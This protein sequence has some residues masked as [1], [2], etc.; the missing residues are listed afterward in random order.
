M[1]GRLHTAALAGLAACTLLPT[2]VMAANECA[3]QSDCG[4]VFMNC[5]SQVCVHKG[6]FPPTGIE[7]G[8]II[9]L[10]ILLGFANN[11]GIGGG[12]LIIP[13]CI[14]MFGFNT[15]QAI[16][17]SNSTIWVGSLVKYFGFSLF[18]K[19]PVKGTT[20]VDYNLVSI[21]LPLVMTGSFVGVIV[22]HVLPE[23]VLTIIL[24]VLLFYLTYDSF[25]KALS[26]WGKET[27]AMQKE[28]LAYKP[29]AGGEAEMAANPTP[30]GNNVNTLINS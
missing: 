27:A 14:S 23:A 2:T 24:I 13:V 4:S 19:N 3:V 10:P 25:K 29:L 21:M 26:L 6:V 20:V 28:K 30:A 9:L 11:G 17:L 22:S 1:K 8:G 12:G 15:I 16:A 18:Q 7:I 5:V